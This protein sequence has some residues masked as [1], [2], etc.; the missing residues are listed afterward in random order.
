M[1][2]VNNPENPKLI[3]FNLTDQIMIQTFKNVWKLLE[4]FQQKSNIYVFISVVIKQLVPLNNTIISVKTKSLWSNLIVVGVLHF[5]TPLLQSLKG[6]WKVGI[7][8]TVI[9]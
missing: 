3:F 8:E 5:T 6:K 7:S 2:W 4:T 9:S 1:K